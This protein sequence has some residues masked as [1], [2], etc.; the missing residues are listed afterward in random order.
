MNVKV[1][2]VVV[3]DG[4]Y[5]P[6]NCRWATIEEQNNNRRNTLRFDDNTPVSTWGTANGFDHES[7]RYLFRKGYSKMEIY[8]ILSTS[9]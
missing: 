4:N 6:G 5:E 2:I 8:S 9:K 7:V 1:L 3:P